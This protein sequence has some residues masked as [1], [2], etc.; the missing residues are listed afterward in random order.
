[1][2]T[3]WRFFYVWNGDN[4]T[5]VHVGIS[6]VEARVVADQLRVIEDR[7]AILVVYKNGVRWL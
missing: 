6:E 4:R 7:N 1:M 3:I 5:E 2:G